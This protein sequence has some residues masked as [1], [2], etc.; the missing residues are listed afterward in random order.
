MITLQDVI[1]CS[2]QCLRAT[3]IEI[4][5]SCGLRKSTTLT[6]NDGLVGNSETG[7]QIQ[8]HGGE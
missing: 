2:K 3:S 8:Q 4:G 7:P 5:P 1:Q 6:S